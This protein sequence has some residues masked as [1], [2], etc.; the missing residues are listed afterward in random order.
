[1]GVAMARK[2]LD[3]RDYPSD[4]NCTVAISADSE[5]ELLETAVQHACTSHGHMDSPE[6]RDKLRKLFRDGMPTEYRKA[7]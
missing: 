6:L 7:A 3:C 2:Y 5:D 1:M 4:K